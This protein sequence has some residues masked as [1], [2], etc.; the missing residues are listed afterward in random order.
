MTVN[1]GFGGQAFLPSVLPKVAAIR[2]AIDDAGLPIDLEVDGGIGPKTAKL[3][4]DAGA[5]VLVAGKA[6]FGGGG[7]GPA[8]RGGRTPAGA[9]RAVRAGLCARGR[10]RGRRGPSEAAAVRWVPRE[11]RSRRPRPRRV[12]RRLRAR[13]RRFGRSLLRPP[14]RSVKSRR[15]WRTPH[16]CANFE[17]WGR[18]VAW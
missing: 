7:R 10:G 17:C 11:P 8:G 14:R 4:V 18:F 3:V 5:R 13:A 6:G 15:H 16:A 9:A 1:P 2:K 12:R